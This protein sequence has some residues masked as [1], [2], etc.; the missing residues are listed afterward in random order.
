MLDDRRDY[1]TNEDE[2]GNRKDYTVEALFDM[3]EESY[4]L[5][6]MRG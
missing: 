5:L 6:K 3:K 4:A 1:I 2:K